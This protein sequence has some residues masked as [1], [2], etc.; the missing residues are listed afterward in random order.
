MKHQSFAV[1]MG[2]FAITF[3]ASILAARGAGWLFDQVVKR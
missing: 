3:A 2:R 1:R